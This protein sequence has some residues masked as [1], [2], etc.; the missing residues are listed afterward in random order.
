KEEFLK[1]ACKIEGVYAP[2]LYDVYYNDDGTIKEMVAN[3]GAPKK[4]KKRIVKDFD[5]VFYPSS[6]VVPF[7]EVVHDRVVD[8]IFRGCIRGCRF[9]QAGYLYR[10]IREKRAQTVNRQCKTLCETS[11]YD[12]IS[13]AS[14]S[15]S[16]YTNLPELLEQMF[17][18]THSE[19]INISLPSLRVDNFSDDLAQKL[20]LI[21]RSGLTFA[22]EAGTQRL[23]DVIN[24]NVSKDEIISTCRKAFH[25]GWTAVKLYFMLGL[26]TETSDDIEGI[27]SLGQNVVDEFY[28]N[29]D[30][31][32]GKGVT[33]NISASSFVPKPFTPFQWEAQDTPETMLLK[34]EFLRKNITTKKI[35]LSYNAVNISYL[36]GIFARGDRKLCRVLMAAWQKGCKFDSWDDHFRFD[37]WMQAFDE[38]GVNPEFYA[39]RKRQFDEVLPWDHMDYGIGK[40]FLIGECKKAYAGETTPNCRQKCSNCGILKLSGGVCDA[41][42]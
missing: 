27:A 20:K 26:P 6:F 37:L 40:E 41:A 28:S 14:L 31:P 34:Q 22:P 29:P 9:C 38:C 10:P 18:W 5:N 17:E 16:D 25:E 11:G 19:T 13:L 39:V 4:I 23:R 30:K 33:V 42:N 32:K 35:N 21:R 15:T 7:I 24:K 12:E 36:E 1:E 2:L 3:C 8:E